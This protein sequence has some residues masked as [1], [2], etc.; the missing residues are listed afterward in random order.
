MATRPINGP[1][2]HH[3]AVRAVDYDRSFLFYTEALGFTRAYGWGTGDGRAAML[4]IGDG[5][6]LEL[7]AGAKPRTNPDEGPIIHYAIRVPDVDSA[8]DRAVNG[9]ATVDIEPKNVD[10]QGDPVVT[11]RIAFV[12]GP[13][14]EVIEFFQNDVL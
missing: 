1:G 4:D 6:Y 14:G 8:F 13:D 11:V 7:F 5:N 3:I 10:L 12:K 2:F 9:G